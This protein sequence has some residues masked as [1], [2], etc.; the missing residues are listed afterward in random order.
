[1]IVT[2]TASLPYTLETFSGAIETAY[3]YSIAAT[4]DVYPEFITLTVQGRRR[5]SD[6]ITVDAAAKV[7]AEQL[8]SI[9]SKIAD[10]T[11]L[12]AS[13]NSNLQG[14]GLKAVSGL[15]VAPIKTISVSVADILLSRLTDGSTVQNQLLLLLGS[16]SSFIKRPAA[17]SN[18]RFVEIEI[19]LYLSKSE[20]E[21]KRSQFILAIAN[22]AGVNASSVNITSVQVSP[23]VRRTSSSTDVSVLIDSLSTGAGSIG[24]QQSASGGVSSTTISSPSLNK[25]TSVSSSDD[26]KSTV[27]GAAVGATAAVLAVALCLAC[28]FRDNLKRSCGFSKP[29]TAASLPSNSEPG[30]DTQGSSPAVVALT[31]PTA[32]TATTNSVFIVGSQIGHQAVNVQVLEYNHPDQA[33]LPDP[34]PRTTTFV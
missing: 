26:N 13:L 34:A 4:L 31:A 24:N 30:A 3:T 22:A 29:D 6:S 10:P 5:R 9:S 2:V 8:S 16:N 7:P 18:P 23:S 14:Y 27:I 15:S 21:S 32:A 20:F 11:A 12:A 25:N 17:A 19:R 1:V 28:I 33:P